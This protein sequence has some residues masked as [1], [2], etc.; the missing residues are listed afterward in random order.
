[1]T[2]MHCANCGDDLHGGGLDCDDGEVWCCACLLDWTGEIGK[3]CYCPTC[4]A[5]RRRIER[6]CH[7]P[8]CERARRMVRAFFERSDGVNRP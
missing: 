4:E 3:D 8:A 7:C 5:E 1:M 2:T 6:H